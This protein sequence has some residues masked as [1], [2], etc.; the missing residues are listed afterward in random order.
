M[1]GPAV[2]RYSER[3]G[4]EV[5]ALALPMVL[6]HSRGTRVGRQRDIAGLCS[7][8]HSLRLSRSCVLTV[9]PMWCVVVGEIC[10]GRGKGTLSRKI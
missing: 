7:E 10:M 1:R 8:T 3:R 6:Y 4:G 5:T 9:D 2:C